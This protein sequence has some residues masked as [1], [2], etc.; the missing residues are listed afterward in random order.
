MNRGRNTLLK[1]WSSDDYLWDNYTPTMQ[2]DPVL[3]NSHKTRSYGAFKSQYDYIL[4]RHLWVIIQKIVSYYQMIFLL[5]I[6]F[7]DIRSQ[8]LCCTPV[9]LTWQPIRPTAHAGRVRPV[10]VVLRPVPCR[11]QVIFNIW[12]KPATLRIM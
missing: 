12:A 1:P 8:Y 7:G 11:L 3:T 5:V 4:E 6:L 2:S 10:L 9:V